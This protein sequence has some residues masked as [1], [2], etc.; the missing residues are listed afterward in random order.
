MIVSLTML[1]MAANVAAYVVT[2][3]PDGTIRPD[4]A[5]AYGLYAANLIYH[6]ECLITHMFLHAGPLHLLFNMLGLLTFG[7]QLERML[8]RGEYLFLYLASGVAG[9]LLQVVV[10]PNIP[11]IGASSAVFGLVGCLTMLRPM[12]MIMFFFVPM[13][14]VL[15]SVL[16]ALAAV[17][18]IESGA[19]THVAHAGHLGGMLAGGALALLYRPREALKGLA[20]V[21]VVVLLLLVG[22]WMLVGGP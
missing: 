5:W 8:S 9:G 15:F 20:A 3:G 11:T 22:Y 6:P 18:V 4:V 2:I 1:L 13:P 19:F 12:S 17:F 14:L 16:Y 7:L 10:T 21:S